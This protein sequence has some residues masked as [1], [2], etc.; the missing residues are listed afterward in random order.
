[1]QT[2]L[3]LFLIFSL[4]LGLF[5]IYKRKNLELQTVFGIKWNNKKIPLIFALLYHTTLGIKAMDAIGKKYS[6]F[7]QKYSKVVTIAGFGFMGLFVFMLG[8]TLYKMITAPAAIPY[9]GA[10]LVL[11]FKVKGQMY[12]PFFY[13][14]IT[15]M[16][17]ATVH[18]FAHGVFA[19]AWNIPVK[20]S[21]FAFLCL[22]GIP[23]IPMAFVN[24]DE[25]ILVKKSKIQQLSTFA[26]GPLANILMALLVILP[27]GFMTIYSDRL[28]QP[29]HL[30]IEP[31][32][33]GNA[34][35]AGLEGRQSLQSAGIDI[36]DPVITQTHYFAIK[37]Q[38]TLA[39]TITLGKNVGNGKIELVTDKG[40]YDVSISDAG[41]IGID[42]T[43]VLQPIRNPYWAYSIKF[44]ATLLGWMYVLNIGIGLVNFVPMGPIDGGRM[45]STATQG[46]MTKKNSKILAGAVSIVCLLLM[47]GLFVL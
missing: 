36:T 11:P 16:T 33:G 24:I 20:S 27:A 43:Q 19:R 47:V 25:K 7:I 5:L 39:E 42:V 17:L 12:V 46:W 34:E 4:L 30:E 22:F 37:N 40:T 41:T 3:I 31:I 38:E 2:D 10:A 18:E 14:L 6:R 35:L 29:T 8:Y 1:M 21:G 28:F 44:I 13:W 26:A 15:L 32:K 23:I 45:F 9:T